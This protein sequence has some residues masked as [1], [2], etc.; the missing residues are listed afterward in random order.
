MSHNNSTNLFRLHW[1]INSP[2]SEKLELYVSLSYIKS[3]H[4]LSKVQDYSNNYKFSSVMVML[5]L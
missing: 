2:M 3:R 1:A 4:N 5:L